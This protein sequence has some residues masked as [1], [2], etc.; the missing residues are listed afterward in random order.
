M[1]GGQKQRLSIARAFLQNPEIIV[2][3]EATASLDLES[4]HLVQLALERLYKNK[5]TLIIAHRLATLHHTD[6]IIVIEDGRIAESGSHMELLQKK[7]LYFQLYR[8]QYRVNLEESVEG[9]A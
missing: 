5:T 7:G 9:S 2:L 4:E 1:S 6:Q 8:E 3:D